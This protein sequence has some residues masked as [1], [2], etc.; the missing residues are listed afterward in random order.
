MNFPRVLFILKLRQEYGCAPYGGGDGLSSGLFNSAR[1]VADMLVASGVEAKLVQ[2]VDNN[3]ID[4]EVTLYRPDV[5]IIEGLWVVPEKFQVLIPLH[6]KVRWI[7]RIHSE[8]P[9]LA[10]EGIA[11]EWIA[12]YATCGISIGCNSGRNFEDVRNYLLASWIG[13]TANEKQVFYLPNYYPL[14]R[15]WWTPHDRDPG[16]ALNVGCFGAIRPL[17]NQ[18]IQALAAIEYGRRVQR[19]VRFYLTMRDCEQGGDQVL[20]NLR[21]MFRYTGNDLIEWPWLAHEDFLGIL[22]RL[23]V[24]MAVSLS[25]SFCIVAAD[26]VNAGV[27]VVVSPEISWASFL[28]KANPTDSESIAHKL[29]LAVDPLSGW[30]ARAANRVGLRKYSEDSRRVWLEFLRGMAHESDAAFA[31]GR[32]AS[33]TDAGSRRTDGPATP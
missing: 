28:S 21:A 9:F 30:V 8:I 3:S 11:M 17:K 2:V 18:L 26:M 19:R 27:P 23:D 13:E 12:R 32:S 4:R 22:D 1:L 24:G 20:K 6:P 5:V 16:D 15:P 7:V 10:M 31:S 25:E 29:A 14:G 33:S